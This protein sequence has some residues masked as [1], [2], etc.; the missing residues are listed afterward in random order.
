MKKILL[1]A[2]VPFFLHYALLNT[3]DCIRKIRDQ[4][5]PILY[6]EHT[7]TMKNFVGSQTGE[8]ECIWKY[9][10]NLIKPRSILQSKLVIFFSPPNNFIVQT[11]ETQKT[12]EKTHLRLLIQQKT[13]TAH[14][15]KRTDSQTGFKSK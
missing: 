12:K 4:N 14:T 13:G 2:A 11:D 15:E 10:P 6:R 3:R 9:C 7:P 8:V 5:G 1:Y